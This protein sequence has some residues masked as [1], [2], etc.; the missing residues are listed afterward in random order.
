[1]KTLKEQLN[2]ALAPLRAEVAKKPSGEVLAKLLETAKRL[3]AEKAAG[4]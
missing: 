2:E 4:V 1:M 3:E